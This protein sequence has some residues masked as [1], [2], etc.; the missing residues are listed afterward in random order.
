MYFS[1]VTPSLFGATIFPCCSHWCGAHGEN[2]RYE[3]LSRVEKERKKKTNKLVVCLSGVKQN[4]IEGVT[5][6]VVVSTL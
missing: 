6:R 3:K 2:G 4:I 5:L 1:G